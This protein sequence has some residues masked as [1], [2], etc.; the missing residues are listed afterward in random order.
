MSHRSLRARA[1]LVSSLVVVGLSAFFL[2]VGVPGSYQQVSE[3]CSL[4]NDCVQTMQ[5]GS[6]FTPT[7][8]AAL[9]LVLG[10][11]IGM[12]VLES[13]TAVSWAGVLGLAAFSFLSLFSIGLLYFP[14]VLI[15]VGLLASLRGP[16]VTRDVGPQGGLQDST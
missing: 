1:A 6:N 16:G 14:L 15:L 5:S 3:E 7:L 10:S 4:P 9:P 13:R 2:F 12:G 8:W 11:I